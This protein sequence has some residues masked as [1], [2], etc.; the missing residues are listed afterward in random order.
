MALRLAGLPAW[1]LLAPLGL[2]IVAHAL[3]THRF[4]VWRRRQDD[5]LRLAGA[6][7]LDH[8]RQ[9]SARSDPDRD[10]APA[11]ASSEARESIDP[12][13]AELAA[14]AGSLTQRIEEAAIEVGNLRGVID[15]VDEPVLALGPEAEVLLINTAAHELLGARLSPDG[16]PVLLED[17]LPQA[18]MLEVYAAAAR[19]VRA[20][21]SLRLSRP[22]EGL[23]IYEVL[24]SP[25]PLRGP[26]LEEG[27]GVVICLRDTTELAT[28]VQLKTDFVANASHELRTPLSSIRAAAE[29]LTD[30]A[31]DDPSMVRRM[32]ELIRG[33]VTR[34]E[35]LVA[36]LLDLSRIESPDAPVE[37][38][39][40][41]LHRLC[42]ELGELFQNERDERADLDRC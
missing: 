27:A 10:P 25:L 2:A 31:E 37:I 15:A 29:T 11:A 21:G 39:P 34:L 4:G 26:E 18:E 22:E 38:G 24:A 7:L 33:N 3:S 42:E 17:L 9:D 30:F 12:E 28:A 16:E 35:E 13:V 1:T 5:R 8:A 20:S 40:L 36:D 32:V 41:D 6:A 19:G 14:A 23:R